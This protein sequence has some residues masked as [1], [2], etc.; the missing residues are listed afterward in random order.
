MGI[1]QE[2]DPAASQRQVQQLHQIIAVLVVAL[3]IAVGY[4]MSRPDPAPAVSDDWTEVECIKATLH[5]V[6]ADH[7]ELVEHGCLSP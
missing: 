3:I 5:P 6:S 7:D 2:A 1:S 4:G